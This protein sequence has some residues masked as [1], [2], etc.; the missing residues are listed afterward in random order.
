MGVHQHRKAAPASVGLGIL[1]VSS[2]RSIE[3]DESGFPD[4]GDQKEDFAFH[5]ESGFCHNRR[6]PAVLRRG[7]E[8]LRYDKGKIL[9]ACRL[10]SREAA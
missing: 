8:F 2:S 3:E 4:I 5:M 1:S 10:Q 9:F 6:G 7:S